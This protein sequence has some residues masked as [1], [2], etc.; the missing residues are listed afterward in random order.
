M[1][2]N[3]YIQS[4]KDFTRFCN[5]NDITKDPEYTDDK[6][7][8]NYNDILVE[9]L[10]EED[11]SKITDLDIIAILFGHPVYFA[12]IRHGF[13]QCFGMKM[14]RRDSKVC[15]NVIRRL[16]LVNFCSVYSSYDAIWEPQ[17][18]MNR[19]QETRRTIQKLAEK[20]IKM[21]ESDPNRLQMYATRYHLP[22]NTEIVNEIDKYKESEET[23]FF[24]LKL[25]IVRG[26]LNG[27]REELM[28]SG[29]WEA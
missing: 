18:G 24:H 28:R 6:Y 17:K 2:Y 16:G 22:Y 13:S 14:M 27:M 21:N 29:Y 19:K 1:N 26:I 15:L 7:E 20:I 9:A 4:E 3:K 5:K 23:N 25:H 10:D 8:K 11:C 12:G